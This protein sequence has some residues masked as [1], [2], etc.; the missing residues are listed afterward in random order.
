M[1]TQNPTSAGNQQ[2]RISVETQ[3]KIVDYV[4]RCS[5][6]VRTQ[7]NMR[8]RM[9]YIDQIYQ[10]ELNF[11]TQ[12]MRYKNANLGGDISKL[13]DITIPVVMPQVETAL[14]TLRDIF[15]S[16]YPIFPVV[17]KPQMEAAALQME[18]T[19]GEQSRR[20]GW[21]AELLNAMRDGLKYNLMAVEVDWSKIQTYAITNDASVSIK[22]GS[23]VQTVYE[24]NSLRRLDI[25]NIIL[26]RRVAPYEQHT[27]AE[28]VG[29][30]EIISAV[31]LKRRFAE[32]DPTLT[33][34]YKEAINSGGASFTH[35][36][37]GSNYFVPQVNPQALLDVTVPGAE[38]W[39]AW[40]G[41]QQPNAPLK[42]ANAYEWTCLYARIIPSIFGMGGSAVNTPQIYKLLVINRK[43][44]VFAQRM[45]NAHNY[46]PIVVA[47]ATEAGLGWQDKSLA[48]NAAPFQ[49][50]ATAVFKS[51]MESQR[52]KVYD[53]IFYDASRINKADIDNA[54]SVARIPVK[55]EAYQQPITNAFAVVPYRDDGVTNM[56][57]VVTMLTD[58]ADI[59]NGQNR[60]QRGQFQK[61]NKTREE[62]QQTMNNS[63]SRPRM[64][65]IT[66]EAR[67]FTP[68]KEIIKTNTLQFQPPTSIYNQKTQAEV[69]IDPVKLRSISVEFKL[70]DGLMPSN[71][72]MSVDS[73]QALF[74]AAGQNPMI[75]QQYDITGAFFYFLKLQGAS[76]IDEFKIQQPTPQNATTPPNPAAA[77]SLPG[78]PQ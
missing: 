11:S 52:R 27:K 18:T 30:T 70:A 48:D 19:I 74:N 25:Y 78:T 66:L 33:F 10:R 54:S 53:R 2:P 63:D 61:G 62:F 55:T 34:N 31:E 71:Q 72:L 46:L 56:F 59:A 45:T 8:F 69:K 3:E 58:Q 13:Q 4:K 49:F 68:I 40:A 32:L 67:F 28:Y 20:F 38:D 44:C 57:N 12:Q 17:A 51:A 47:Q 29:Y 1:A 9:Q 60:V 39:D 43:V 23:S 15:L 65:A 16:S 35:A 41:M 75:S 26:D 36:I 42:Y 37:N 22:Q 14:D 76:W 64:V 6:I 50:A 7:F 73:F 5:D 21:S 77:G 24:G